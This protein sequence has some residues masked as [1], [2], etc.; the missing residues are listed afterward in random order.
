MLI[1]EKSHRSLKLATLF[2]WNP[3]QSLRWKK[4]FFVS[5]SVFNSD[6]SM[7]VLFA[8]WYRAAEPIFF[9]QSSSS[10]KSVLVPSS[11][12]LADI[13]DRY[14]L[15]KNLLDECLRKFACLVY[16]K[17]SGMRWNYSDEFNFSQWKSTI[18]WNYFFDLKWSQ[19]W[20]SLKFI[21]L[22]L[23]QTNQVWEKTNELFQRIIHNRWLL[24]NIF[25]MLE[26]W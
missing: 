16:N 8:F 4:T 14:N 5:N 24:R 26:I 9:K 17:I 21:A 1:E 23:N 7:Q 20:K 3:D 11:H 18:L 2:S 10:R 22:N 15:V 25:T 13:L 12:N 19:P 6:T